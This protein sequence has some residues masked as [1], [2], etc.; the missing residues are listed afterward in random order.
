V[1]DAIRS[2]NVGNYKEARY[3]N[4]EFM[5]SEAVPSLAK[6]S[7]DWVYELLQLGEPVAVGSLDNAYRDLNQG[8]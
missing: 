4:F 3:S 1:I 8:D 6:S 2:G 5:S 7:N